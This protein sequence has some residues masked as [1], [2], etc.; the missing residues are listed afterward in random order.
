MSIAPLSVLHLST[1]D[2]IGGSSRSAYRVHA[3][4]RRLGVRSRM[5]VRVKATRDP[6]VEPMAGPVVGAADFLADG[7]TQL[8]SL[9]YLFYPSSFLLR[10]RRVFRDAD[11]VQLYNTHGNYFA[12]TALPLL[13]RARP[14]VWRLSDM[15]PLTGHCAYSYGCDRWRSGC[16][17]CPLLGDYPRLRRDTTALLWRIKRRAYS[18]CR[19]TVV[20][21][22]RWLA[23]LVGQSPLLGAFPVHVIPNGA[24]PD[25]YRPRPRQAARAS[26]GLPGAGRV[27][28]YSAFALTDRRKGYAVFREAMERLA[29]RGERDLLVLVAGSGGERIATELP[30]AVHALGAVGDEAVM[31]SAYAAAD[32]FVL[33]TLAENF[34]NA[35]LES[36]AC[37]TPAVAFDVGGVSEVLAHMRTGY[38]VSDVE[39]AGLA[40]GIRHLLGD[41]E[42]RAGMGRECRATVEREYTAAGEARRFLDLYREV[43]SGER[44]AALAG[45]VGHV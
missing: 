2:A 20:T 24:D 1:S 40:G 13:A 10:L 26:L 18:A 19:L 7:V 11:I 25:I 30:F 39:A 21:P 38:L 17:A 31:A 16:G 44:S 14:L 37:G 43:L 27:I 12:H 4:L 28:L 5:V 6:D 22:S 36:F 35:L 42:L 32:V 29:A 3:G 9:Q 41:A 8:L 23:G 45:E 15:W 34:P 33:P